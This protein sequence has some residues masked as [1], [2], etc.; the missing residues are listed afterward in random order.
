MCVCVCGGGGGVCVCVWWWWCV[1]VCVCVVVRVCGGACVCG[2][3]VC[4][5]VC[6]CVV[7]RVCVCVCLFHTQF[8]LKYHTSASVPRV[9]M[10]SLSRST[11]NKRNYVKTKRWLFHKMRKKWYLNKTKIET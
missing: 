1:C 4:G 3:G 6:V 2:G 8:S 5:G 9:A 10:V 11:S 7:V